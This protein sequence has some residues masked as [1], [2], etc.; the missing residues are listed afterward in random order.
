MGPTWAVGVVGGVAAAE[1]HV[2]VAAFGVAFERGGL[3]PI[4]GRRGGRRR[5]G[6]GGHRRGRA[7]LLQGGAQCVLD[8]VMMDGTG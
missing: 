6:C 3:R 8:N 5:G 1:A 7:G 2:A 4:G